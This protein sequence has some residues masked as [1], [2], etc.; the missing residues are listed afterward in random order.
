MNFQEEMEAEFN[1]KYDYVREAHYGL[2]DDPASLE[3]E[4]A[5]CAREWDAMMTAAF[6]PIVHPASRQDD[7]IPF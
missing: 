3:Y 4:M 1:A 5:E 6:G 7:E 2:S